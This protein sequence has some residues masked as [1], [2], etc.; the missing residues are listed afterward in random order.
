MNTRCSIALLESALAGGLPANDEAALNRHLEE[1]EECGAALERMAGGSAWCAEAASLLTRDELDA[2]LPGYPGTMR[3]HAAAWCPVAGGDEWSEVDFTVEHLEPSDEPNVLGRLGGYDVLE[4]IGHGGMG[5]VLKAFDRE[6]KRYV[7]IKVLAPHL[8]QSSL[9]KKRFARE[10]QAAAAVVHPHVLAIHQ[11]QPGGR[12]PFLVMPLVAGESLA[13]R[14]AAQGRL[15][16]KETLRIGMQA[17]AGLAA[18][19]EQ[20]LVHRDVKPANILLE[21]GVE[22]AVLTD[23]GLA[24]AADDVTLTRW[25]IIAG[26][27]QYMSPEQARGEPLDGRS[28][29]FSLGCVLY[30]MATGV[31]PFRTD[32]VMATMRRLV[33]DS[34][35]AMASLNPELPPWFIA[36]VDR[37]L[38]KDPSRRFGSAKEVSELLEGCLAHV[39]QPNSVPLPAALPKPAPRRAWRP[40]VIRFKGVLAVIAALGAGL[41]GVFLL[42]TAPPDMSGE[43]SGEDWG[44]VVLK[45][46]SDA[47]YT[48]TYSDTAGKQ[49]GKIQL[50]WSRVERRFNG[51]WREGED[52]FGELSVRLLGDEIRGALT[53]DP[54][55]KINPA[56]PRLADLTWTRAKAAVTTAARSDAAWGDWNV[57]W[58]VRLRAAKT[59]WTSEQLP[60]F[61]IDLRK[62]ENAE[63]DAVQQTL[64][65]W[66]LDVDGRRFRLC[67]SSTSEE[68]T[69]TFEPGTA[70]EGFITFHFHRDETGLHIR[71][72]KDGTWINSYA[73]QPVEKDGQVLSQSKPG[74]HLQWSPGKHVVRIAFPVPP[75]GGSKQDLASSN[76]VEIQVQAKPKPTFGPAI[77]KVTV[78]GNKVVIEGKAPAHAWIHFY[79]GDNRNNGWGNGFLKATRF[80]TSLEMG[81]QGL[82]CRVEPEYCKPSRSLTLDGVKQIGTTALSEGQ[83]IFRAGQ[84]QIGP[85]GTSSVTIGQWT[86]RSGETTPIRV[87]VSP[88]RQSATGTVPEAVEK[89]VKTIS[90]CAE[91]DPRVAEAMESLLQLNPAD[92]VGNLC[93]FLDSQEATVRRA[94]IY[95]LWQVKFASIAPAVPRLLG[96]CAHQEDLTR[97]MAALALGGNRVPGSI[98]ALEKMTSDDPSG[99]A[100]RCA[101]IALGFLGDPA[102]TGVLEKA[103]KDPETLVRTNAQA[104]LKML[105]QAAA[106]KAPSPATFGPVIERTLGPGG[107]HNICLDLETGRLHD[108]P[109][110]KEA[111]PLNPAELRAWAAKEG[112]D[113]LFKEFLVGFDMAVFPM[114]NNRMWDNLPPA[115]VLKVM[116]QATGATPAVIT[117]GK[118]LRVTVWFKTRKGTLGVLQFLGYTDLPPSGPRGAK[119]RYKLVVPGASAPAEKPKATFGPVFDRVLPFGAICY[120]PWLQFR[121]GNILTVGDGTDKTEQ[122]Y[123][124]E[125]NRAEA[126]GGVDAEA[127]G[128][129]EGFQFLGKGCLFTQVPGSDWEKLT[130]E[131]AVKQLQS[132]MWIKGVLEPNKKDLPQTWLFKTSR[133]EMGILELLDIV[134]DERGARHDGEKG[135]GVKLRYKLVQGGETK[136]AAAQPADRAG[137]P[138][139]KAPSTP[140]SAATPALLAQLPQLRFLAWRDEWVSQKPHGA[141]HADGS[142]VTDLSEMRLLRNNEPVGPRDF[143][144][145]SDARHPRFLHFWFSHPLCDEHSM[146]EVTSDGGAEQSPPPGG[147]I[148]YTF[149]ARVLA[150]VLGNDDQDWVGREAKTGTEDH[151]GWLVSTVAN[152]T[153]MHPATVRLRYTLGPWE[154]ER[155]FPP[156]KDGLFDLGHGS[157][158]DG[159]GEARNVTLRLPGPFAFC[160]I[161]RDKNR[162]A[163]RQ[164][165]VWAVTTDGRELSP[166]FSEFVGNPQADSVPQP[167]RLYFRVPLSKIAHFRIATRPVRTVE[168]QNVATQPKPAAS[169]AEQKQSPA[170][171]PAAGQPPSSPNAPQGPLAVKIRQA[172]KSSAHIKFVDVPAADLVQYLAD[173]HKIPFH[174][175]GKL[176]GTPM[177]LDVKGVT[178]AAGLQAIEDKYPSLQFVV[179]DDGLLLTEREVAKRQGYYPAVEFAKSGDGPGR[180]NQPGTK[181]RPSQ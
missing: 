93:K 133:G 3:D 6:L 66:L 7:A 179:R 150:P 81:P 26:T 148:A 64:H 144:N 59:N 60:E 159:A 104:A 114:P 72:G 109:D 96:L 65:N 121:S 146:G 165:G 61:T 42:P 27:P 156:D 76:P 92:V 130:A 97:G 11:V 176:E 63:P 84:P 126:V 58:S 138:P 115:D 120:M 28:D 22:R 153:K 94:A 161:A 20:G 23:F 56:T 170:K 46:T 16:L 163:S 172:L 2:A 107:Q 89:A 15:E 87:A 70:R 135:Y 40:P 132:A 167:W 100:R 36:I 140:Q 147:E 166:Y 127:E 119:I 149:T 154:D 136:T 79:A 35:R 151:C 38:E 103:L 78:T 164:V 17:A 160:K 112:I 105:R 68:H 57:S 53:T 30:E 113:L 175:S 73:L 44:Q 85:D 31:S 74:E 12:L 25:G 168:F 88:P 142:L 145:Y 116:E 174:V 21:K 139:A 95:I 91:G 177:T 158:F 75:P 1:C 180:T 67:I 106:E 86:A 8:A 128:S 69:K 171:A 43:W 137:E 117:A 123:D 52:R 32:S 9:A 178:L 5:V 83:L 49:P 124:E 39:Q 99:Y 33:D 90:T 80:T 45:K 34:P 54:K 110:P 4:I 162:D 51:T 169:A 29:L 10:A 19:H 181:S 157:T 118:E 111:N 41:L 173:C 37:L 47:E 155:Q 129:K 55:S 24:R 125:M 102:A 141:F 108:P 71:T 122:Q 13:Q 82:S 77:E 48:G 50:R 152:S 143:Q 101:A 134:P 98:G 18:A 131:D 14:L 62:R